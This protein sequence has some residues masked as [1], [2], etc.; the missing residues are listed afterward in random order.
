MDN[1]IFR[2]YLSKLRLDF[3]ESTLITPNNNGAK[4]NGVIKK[5][6]H[7]I[8]KEN[9]MEFARLYSIS[10]NEILL[11]G[12]SLTLNK[13]NF[14]DE[15]LIFNQ[16]NVPF[17]AKFENR[18][19]SIKEFLEKIHENYDNTLEFDGDVDEKDIILK[20]EFYYTFDENLKPDLEYSNYLSMV[21]NDKSVLLS[22]FYNDELYS[23]DFIYL[24]LSSFEKI[25]N[26]IIDADI[27]KTKICDIA[28]VNEKD[29]IHFSEVEMPLLHKRF[30][31]QVTLKPNEIA[32]VACDG[33]LTYKQLNGK[34]N[35]IANALIEKG[36]EPKSNVLVMLS[37]NT[38]L[39]ASI[40][41]ILKAGCAFIPIDP[42]Y[43]QERINYVYEN[44][45]ADYI[46]S[47]D[48]G[49]N[50]LDINELLCNGNPENP[51][52][53]VESD[54]LAYIIYTSGS[55]GKPK[56]VMISHENI[57][58]QIGR[59]P[60]VNY[61]NILTISTI[62]FVMSLQDILT[63]IT[64][65]I[66]LIFS[67][68][69]EAKNII[70]LIKLIKNQTPEVMS[71]TPSRLLSYLEV[72]EFCDAIKCFKCIIMGGELFPIK[73][74][75]TIKKYTEATIYNAYGQSE[76][77]GTI[78]Y[79]EI[80]NSNN[81]TVGKPLENS[82]NDVRDIDGKLLPK[83]VMGELC[84]AG[85]CVG[86]GY[87]NLD[88]TKDVFIEINGIPYLK[89]GDYAIET[90]DGE[91]I[92]KERI[93][94]QI[95]L[96]GLRIEIGEIEYNIGEYPQ[97]TE[98]VVVIKK[99]NNNM[100][101]CA[102][103]TADEQI[104][105]NSL[106]DYLKNRL[107]NY[108]VPT[109]FM[110]LDRIPRTPN[111][112]A[113]KKQL[114]EPKLE[115]ENVP[116]ANDTEEKLFEMLCELINMDDFG[117]TDDLYALGFTS[118]SLIKFNAEIYESFDISLDI[119]RLLDNPTIR[120]ISVQ[121][122]NAE[123]DDDLNELIKS[124]NQL[125]FYPLMDNQLGVYYEC[126]QNPDEAQ[127]NLPAMMR[128]DKSIDP[129]RLKD[130]IIKTIDAYPY[131]KTRIVIHDG[132][133]MHKRDDSIPIDEIPIVEVNDI[134]DEEIEKDNVKRFELLNNQL[135]RAKI[136]KTNNETILFFD[137]HHIIS[138][139]ES[140][141][142]LFNNFARAYDGEEIESEVFDGYICSLIENENK[143]SE[144]YVASGKYFHDQLT[145]EVDSTILTP[146][147]NNGDEQGR[148]DSVSKIIDSELIKEFCAEK[149]ISPNVFFMAST[150]L[151]LNKYTFSDKT[152]LTTIFN[153]RLNSNYY[154]TQS[155]L[156]KTLPIVSINEDRN[157][158]IRQLFNQIDD[159]WKNG[160]KHCDYPYIKIAE[161]FNLKPEFLYAYHNLEIDNI[162][163]D[164][165]LS[166]IKRLNSLETNYKITFN[167]NE[168]G[169]NIELVVLYNNVLYS[170]EYIKTFL[171][172]VL[173]ILN[174]FIDGKIE[175]LR[176]NEIELNSCDKLPTFAPVEIP[177]VHKRF[178]KQVEENLDNVALVASDVTLTYGKLNEKSNRIANALIKKGVKPK[179]NVLV[180]LERDSNLIAS[181]LGVLKAGCAFVPIDP[182]Y[183]QER[184]NYIYE[185]SQ[186]DYLIADGGFE[187]S[188]D[189]KEL[190]KEENI[191]NPQVDI[192]SDDLA[193][194]I[195]TSGSTGNPKGVMISHKNI[196]NLFSKSEDNMIYNSYLKMNKTL[197]LSTVSFD[198][199]LL[200]FMSLT[201]GLEL[202]LA[203]DIEVK[204]VGDL[205]D[206]IKR[207]KPDSFPIMVPSRL[208]QYLEHE[209][210]V[211]EL[212]NFK[213][214]AL[215]GEM[216]PQDLVAQ[217]LEFS[218][219]EIFNL[220]GPTEA[221]VTC[222]GNKVVNAENIIVGK[223]LH[224]FITDV[225]DIDGKLLPDGVM[226]ELYIGGVGVGKGY[227]NLADKTKE[228]FLTINDVHYYKSGDYAIQLPNG[229]IDI[230]GRIDNQI[231]LRGLRIEIGEIES[232]IAN[233]PHIKQVV[234]VIKEINNNDHLCAYYT[235]DEVIDGIEL[236]EFLKERLTRY[237]VPTVFMQIDEMPITPNG[238]TDLKQLPE[239]Q[240]KFELV[241]PENKT[242][243]K[244]FEIVSSII[245]TTEFG[246]TDDLYALGFTSLTLMKLNSLIY[247]QMNGN[248]DI[249]IIFNEP[250]IRNFAIELDNSFEKV[251]CLEELVESAKSMEYYPL[252]ENQLG[253]YY[254]CV[255]NPDVIRYVIPETVRFNNDVDAN[256]LKDAVIKTIEL[257][258]YLKTRIVNYDGEL[259]QKRCDDVAIDDIEIVKVD[260][261]S[262][263]EIVK[264]DFGPISIEDN[265]L[266]KF[267]IYETPDE[268]VLFSNFHHIISDGV[269]QN[270]LFKDIANVYENRNIEEEI[271]DGYIY[272]I[273]EKDAEN[274]EMYQSSKEFFDEKLTQK[275][276]STVLTPDINGNPGEGN[277][278]YVAENI[279]S[280]LINEFCNENSISKNTLFMAST[281]LSLN[282]FTF[283]D[284]TLITTIFNGRS[285]PNYFNTQGFLVKTIP[286]I[287]NNENRQTS[288]RDFIKSVD[289]RWKDT[290]KN[291]T[292]PYIKL[293]DEY[294][295]KPEFFYAYHE[296]LES[297][298]LIINNKSY[299]S[300][301][302]ANDDLVTVDSKIYLAIYDEGNEFKV[303]ME[304]NDQLYSEDYVEMFIKSMKDILTQFLENDMDK[305]RICDVK[306]RDDDELP[307]FSEVEIPFIHKRFEKQ[308]NENPQNIALVASD[309]TLTYGELNRKA[310]RVANALINKGIEPNSNVLVMIP[311]DSNLISTILGVLKA[312]CAF[313]PIDINYPQGRIDYIFENSQADYLIADG[314][315]ENSI[316][317]KELLSED[318]VS[319]PHVQIAPDDL[320][321][322]IYTS[323]S[324]GNP[325]GVMTSHK[326]IT[327]L[328]SESN[329][330]IVYNAYSKMKKTLALST[331][332][333]DAFLL[334]FMPL[335]FG[336]EM[337]LANDSEIKNIK[338]L[339]ELIK[340]EKPDSL[341]FTAPSRFKQYL[342]YDEFVKEIPNFKYIAVGGEMVP[343][344][345]I[346]QLLEYPNLDVYNIYGPTETTVICNAY[347]LTSADNLTIGKALHNCITEIRDIDGKRVPSGVIGEL[348]I[349]GNGVARGYYNMPEKT[350][351]AF[352][353]INDIPY[354]RSGDYAI[355][356]PNGNLVIKG[357]I[358]NQIKLR[359]LR[360]EIGEIE[361]NIS[362]FPHV[363]QVAVVIKEINNVEHLCAYF[364]ADKNIDI[365]LLKKYLGDKLTE[366]MVPTVFMP[367]DVMPISPNG[368]TDIKKLPK[369]KLNLEY[370]EAET[371]TEE[372][373]VEFVASIAN[374]N[375]FGTTDDLY[376]LGF[377]SLTLM[378]LNSMIFNETNVNIDI[379][380]LFA[381]PTIK[382]LA[383]KIDNN[384]EYEIN[385]DEIIETAKGR[386]YFPLTSNQLGIYYEC[387]QT[388]K[389]KYTMPFAVRFESSIDPNKLKDALI[390]TVEAHPY[391]KTRI[392]NTDDGKILQKRCDDAEIE[393]IEI[394]E[395]DSISNKEIMDNDV[396]PI[397]LDNNQL[398][399]FKIYKTPT[400]TIL[401]I[402]FH[403]IISDG[404]SQG[405]FF[406]DLAKAYNN[407]EIEK[408]IVDGYAYSLIEDETSISE[409]SEKFFK[410]QFSQGM[411]STVLTPNINGN[412]DVGN[413]KIVSDQ[414][415][416]NFVRNFCK[417]YSISPNVLFM[418]ATLLSLNKFT[419]TDKSLIT[420]IFNGRANSNYSNMQGMLVK[421][422]PIFVNSENRDMMVEDYIKIVDKA[423]KD[424]L[425]HSNY[426]YTK[427]AEDYQ[428]KPEFFFAFHESLKSKI[429][430]NGRTYEAVDL[431]GTVSTDY[432]INIDIF[433]DGDHITLYLEYNDQLYTKE[434]VNL[435][436]R[437][438]KYILFQF[439]VNDM[440]KLKLNDIEL[441]EG[442]IPE[443]EEIDTPILHK[444]FEK[445]VVEKEDD[446]ALVACDV[447]LTYGELNEKS[448]RIANAL[449]KKGVK[450][451]SNVLIMLKR[452][453]N[454]IASILGVLKAGCTFVPIDPEYPQERINYIFENS[455][456]DYIISNGNSENSLNVN[457]LLKEEN[458][459][460]PHVDV[461]PDDL[462]YMI[463][464]SGSTGKPKGVMISH[465]NICNQA[466]NPKSTYESLLCI[467]TI[468]FDVSVDDILTSLSNGLKLILADD[469]QI[470]NIVE[471]IKLIDENKPEV[472]EITPSR[473]GSYLELNE[474]C[475]VISCLKCVF[476]GGEQFSAKVYEDLRKCS[477]AIVYNSYG[478]T[479]TTITSNNK[480]VID[481]NELTVGLPLTNYVTD[482]RDI[483]GK[484]IPNG[485]MGE[486]YIG[487][488]G[489]GKGYYNM[490]EKTKESFLTING[491]PYYRS[492]DY[493]IELPNGEID[494]RGRIDNQI[495]LRG[496]RIEIG[497]I[498]SNISK[499]PN[500]KQAVVVIKKINN[501]DHLCA[502][503]V[504][505][506]II[507]SDDLKEFLKDRLTQ[508]MVPTVF[509][510]IDEMPQTPN[511]KTDT[512]KL[513]EPKRTLNYVA[514]KT[515]LEQE[516]CAI[517]SS[518]LNIESV[519]V[520]DNFFEIGGTS[521]IAS[522]LIIELLKQGYNVRYD[523]IFKNKTP[524]LL[525]KLLSGESSPEDELNVEASIIKNYNYDE[526]NRLLGENTLENFLDGE[527]LELGN[528]LLTG[529]TGFLGI[530]ILYEFIKKEE[531]KIYCMLRKGKFNSCEERLIDLMDYYFDE[532]LSGLI[533]SRIIISEGDITEIEDFKKLEDE[534]IDTII[535]SAAIVKHY[536][537]DD[538]IFKV[539]V[540]GV[541]NG[542]KFA[543]TRNNVRYIQISTISVLSSYS[544]NEEAYPNQEYN[545]R[546]LYYEQ[547][548]ENKYLASKF[549]AERMVL[550]A[551][552]KGLSVKIIRLG[553]LM[554]RYSDGLFQRNYDT[555]A[556]LN[557]IN[558]I[559]KLKAITPVMA[560]VKTDMSQIDYVAKGILELCKTPEKSRVFHCMNN[561][562]IS[563]RDIVNALN[564]YGYGIEEVDADKF[565]QI[566]EQNM[567]EN[568]QG[569]IMEG[570]AIDDF[571][572]ENDFEENVEIEQ[573]TKILH[574]LGFDWPEADASYL[575]RLIDYLNKFNYFE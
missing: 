220:Y 75:N 274:S 60:L 520:E 218:D 541:I 191:D 468:S 385:M 453:S 281:I 456:A 504:A 480:E 503:Y 201:F 25:I 132:K 386:E 555:N 360:I 447:T 524:R 6:E 383:D 345:L 489:V 15:T 39:I 486:L 44:S 411:E 327:N 508:Y 306:L 420:T 10:I 292:Y 522:K 334:D 427:L 169:D 340:R 432:K 280:E 138:D 413:I 378:K 104:D 207:E 167:V 317:V 474:F 93:D 425:T 363:K 55:T 348:Y 297:G 5:L 9:L 346:A 187:N 332:S 111:G 107:V 548:L 231:K 388:E 260:S 248:L 337:V 539:N 143:N 164:N 22:L 540:D 105:K 485:V 475:D 434:Y 200:E 371:E 574:S 176:I 49:K 219:L 382:S 110:Q 362:K 414:V 286:F 89:T 314:I 11:A 324:T 166:N 563:F 497:E 535:N 428:L 88:Q 291:A 54:D 512:K 210:F 84:Y 255:Q 511:G 400:E 549:L 216:V 194:M 139:G 329:D 233:F 554:S 82:I 330:S 162:E 301:L 282:K 516:I 118:L 17:A 124:S 530:H 106:K 222:N 228:V 339:V 29:D 505:D 136:Y 368:K 498:E 237:M 492:G 288:M 8:K 153:G 252:T 277:I 449:I 121:I 140:L 349:G 415:N 446:V 47:N 285:S 494:I 308:A 177:F 439:F 537:A 117:V 209:E 122:D 18:E 100:H 331:V 405:I 240:L 323:G 350:K 265:Q 116:P 179:S 525:A 381:N 244:L 152:L 321:Y 488:V 53:N 68:D 144:E 1:K 459:N 208:R 131:L 568:I 490:P 57:C 464:T 293:A 126:A 328:F 45:Q 393:E 384:V 366:Y 236:K 98:N 189:V 165:K 27:E 454:L 501:V 476:L 352:I 460:N 278:K 304:Y 333:F 357:R 28:L 215:G 63:G 103:Y 481:I 553:N 4:E 465:K 59:N 142:A 178:E 369:P 160:I 254:E 186:A 199:F 80:I 567:N 462:A 514:P 499:Y 435:F 96:R 431:D 318:N 190:L 313:I 41:G 473:M 365:N 23:E 250:T 66:K 355:E 538:Y 243:E 536:T 296:F 51:N 401:F 173:S 547:N 370:V 40:L 247:E 48:S 226:G 469:T 361:A 212:N 235:A 154:N 398:F 67:S 192:N 410:N 444:R 445:Q 406:N 375:N 529:V 101:L 35:I 217:L 557:T 422:L 238:K 458:T 424:A 123:F 249:S 157:I 267:K 484:L 58:N 91:F 125:T 112:K 513:P 273:L 202:V 113:N 515:K 196:T 146:N 70:D 443:F 380:S 437:S 389:I 394:V 284:K 74:F 30:E 193:Y 156:V 170:K 195:Y 466:Q 545:E 253:V 570:F 312:G 223:A 221:S 203:N 145:K 571:D 403:H 418:G 227:Y 396:K 7:E 251:S 430:L 120:H 19:I 527:E 97:I 34:A 42:E 161:E 197:A 71:I 528:V 78:T 172:S 461:G 86:K 151:T 185:N 158:S 550:E 533:G 564:V 43:P 326:N 372:K 477:D 565:K 182:E 266:F 440:D 408:E 137:I 546:T 256:R 141:S 510:Q 128:F 433:D 342:E 262:D 150:I 387:I 24:F 305:F 399:R 302:L 264:N 300:R 119:T 232:N 95:K 493:A 417:D 77:S 298:E 500:V 21:E 257:H 551:A 76:V 376:E 320:A 62:S 392:I 311:R 470:R 69:S 509:M 114:P 467:T 552:T 416:S 129:L 322:M 463:Y 457:E 542:L 455:Q 452:N 171:D 294:Q 315:I 407:E 451:K 56:G 483:D 205:T 426:P 356:L 246:V 127:Y 521:L 184:I 419:F 31:K 61:G 188:I 206:L 478:P 275:I 526:I 482:V 507:D 283:N 268:V 50:I 519:G 351:E 561:H 94:N 65:G 258:P 149:R 354:Y 532:D 163:L 544:L 353:K 229:E 224:N 270:N 374:T 319:N 272:S 13:F 409:A 438:I 364:T 558:T 130:A 230:K 310:N 290:L 472:L 412:P 287:I 506:E 263:E 33:T 90:S 181:I 16:N 566:Y 279:S 442:E 115:F 573:T 496:L 299:K 225:R 559:K 213:Y 441:V 397:P 572:E 569:I 12:L 436:L 325:K 99:I 307:E 36:I 562:Y 211:H 487:G 344:D 183:P 421:T 32:L 502:Y 479:E 14:S 174:Q 72:N 391:L 517:F 343:Q 367:L 133:L 175:Q 159:I 518:I 26:Q 214:I 2:E 242:E 404:V 46:I 198:A 134:S 341:T 491:I 85:P 20:P 234:V 316:D 347:K 73:A 3:D 64:N 239:P 180:M 303:V 531:G 271:V 373:L 543:Q 448:N 109:A 148:L 269:S 108:M 359:G 471:L 81:I 338:E 309:T 556:F 102:Y 450:P 534:E 276:E 245:D 295:L 87:Y 336:L 429:E 155:F 168:S 523:V 402:D 52:V 390:G 135:F 289:N 92:V 575:K 423:W 204:N 261:I 241:M 377:T 495:K 79:K 379:T 358:D 83:G 335:T 560:N 259:K 37:R 395:I 147:L 38:N